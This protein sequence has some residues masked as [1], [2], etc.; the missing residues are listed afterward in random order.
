M[1]NSNSVDTLIQASLAAA[2]SD[3]VAAM[4]SML[5]AR[6]GVVAVL[7]YGNRLREA[8]AGGLMDFYVL[9]DGDAAYQGRSLSA[10]ANRLLPPNVYFET[11]EGSIGEGVAAKVAVMRLSAF[12]ARMQPS[13]WDTT[14]WARFSQP[15]LLLYARD[16]QA[17]AATV[18][19]IS[20]AHETAAWWAARLSAPGATAQEAWQTLFTH[21]YGAELRVET[22]GGRAGQI[23]GRA[24]PLYHAL[25]EAWIAP[26][27]VSDAERQRA[28]R[29]WH[30]RRRWGKALNVARLT[31]A[32]FTFRGGIAYALSKIE[33]HSGRPVDI[34]PWE[35]RLP[36]LAAPAV[37]FRLIRQRRLR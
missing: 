6:P 31:K 24:L 7:F 19:A 1:S 22:A 17:R 11:L 23:V 35:R 3:E 36:W 26:I 12:L 32:A 10:A 4:A 13:T 15:A 34:K 9:T 30:R 28:H 33:R 16:D 29:S 14:L 8:G 27:A 2:P 21:T 37:L 18:R 5:S 25:H 20:A